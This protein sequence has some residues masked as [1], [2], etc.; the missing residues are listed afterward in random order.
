MIGFSPVG[1]NRKE[2][3][4]PKLSLWGLVDGA[5]MLAG[6][7]SLCGFLGRFGWLPELT[8]HFRVQ[9]LAVLIPAAAAAL[10]RRHWIGS[11]LFSVFA[12]ANFAVIAPYWFD[13]PSQPSAPTVRLRVLL[14]NVRTQN[15]RFAAVRQLV[16]DESPDL[17]VVEEIDSKWL[18]EL[19]PLRETHPHTLSESREDNFGIAL[20]SRLPI[21]NGRVVHAGDAGV[22]SVIGEIQ[23]GDA[24]A[25]LIGTHPVPPGN[26]ENFRLRNG[27]LQAISALAR[28]QAAPVIVLGDLNV[29]PWSHFFG[30]FLRSSGLVD[31]ARGRG[32]PST[33]PAPFRILGIPIDHCL[34]SPELVVL[35]RRVGPDIGSDHYPLIVDL[36]Q[37]NP[38]GETQKDKA[39]HSTPQ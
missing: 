30:R 7:L 23:A 34:V 10:L 17:V 4:R 5:G 35:G 39:T 31:T 24:T 6:G 36:G 16:R 9:Y 8:S 2:F 3:L 25:T 37:R 20:F 15:E 14:V 26:P 22:P 29:T 12:L 27:Q 19:G 18:H 13:R 32:A 28:N 21:R 38:G 11:G 33:W 1:F